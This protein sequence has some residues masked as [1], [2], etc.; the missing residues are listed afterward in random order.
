MA[1]ID[2]WVSSRTGKHTKLYGT[3]K[4]YRVDN[5]GAPSRSFAD[6]QLTK[7][8]EHDVYVR[9][10]LARGLQPWDHRAGSITL[11]AYAEKWVTE[12]HYAPGSRDKALSLLRN[13]VYPVLGGKSM[14][15]IRTSTCTEFFAAMRA[16]RHHGRPY[17]ASVLES[18]YTLVGS[19]LRAA[20]ADKVIAEHPFDGMAYTPEARDKAAR[21]IW[22]Q[23][24]V[25]AILAGIP[26]KFRALVEMT[27]TH[28]LRQGEA[29]AIAVEDVNEL[30]K[31]VTV[32]HQV[33]RVGGKLV[34][35]RPKGGRTR[36]VPL[37]NT[38]ARALKAHVAEHGTRAFTCECCPGTSHVIFTNRLGH[39]LA[40]GPFNA[41]VWKP[42]LRAAGIMPTRATGMHMLR[43]FY[44]SVMIAS[45][46]DALKIK[47]YM[48]HKSISIT[49]DVYG[50]LL[51][52]AA[53]DDG[54][55]MDL[56][57]DPGSYGGLTGKAV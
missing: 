29:F 10:Q 28:G 40:P 43:H 6:R 21:D 54:A 27:A 20:V 8:K 12:H 42:A 48:G 4:R 17:S 32:R 30:R 3:G 35:T 13:H 33:R 11:K 57:F 22:E 51:D 38:V 15:A 56:S 26:D 36:T 1:V 39:L 18:V 46:M 34:L 45:G 5:T 25:A 52:H 31:R 16:K 7:A 19:I 50:H 23:S 53:K 24:T 9:G 44:A 41:N 37:T 14:N 47:T 55:V 49:Y 2:L